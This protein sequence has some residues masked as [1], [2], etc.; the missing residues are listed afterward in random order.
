MKKREIALLW[1]SARLAVWAL[2]VGAACSLVAADGWAHGRS[3][4]GYL[5]SG[6]RRLGGVEVT[7]YQAVARP[8][9][10]VWP[11]AKV[12]GRKTTGTN[13]YF[14]IS[15]D[16]VRDPDAVLYLVAKSGPWALATIVGSEPRAKKVIINDLTSVASAYALAQFIHGRQ[17]AGN[18]V[19]LKNAASMFL[20]LVD[21]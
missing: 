10:G 18:A 13:G 14:E 12:L 17:V 6:P 3:V 20:N 2:L 8:Q 15:Y 16:D 21:P 19:G 9:A 7:L 1:R 4:E 5:E 11:W